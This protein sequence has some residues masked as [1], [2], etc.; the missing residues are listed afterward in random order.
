MSLCGV[1]M[2]DGDVS[3]IL[4]F[5]SKF[6]LTRTKKNSVKK[7]FHWKEFY[8]KFFSSFS[9]IFHQIKF[10]QRS[11]GIVLDCRKS[12]MMSY[13]FAFFVV[14]SN[15]KAIFEENQRDL[16]DALN[17]LSQYLQTDATYDNFTEANVKVKDKTEY[18]LHTI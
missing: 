18:V 4:N 13:I 11:F 14:E 12:L 7:I 16:E 1:G 10:L 6:S 2:L 3:T 8:L 17:T 5:V 9:V 15:Q